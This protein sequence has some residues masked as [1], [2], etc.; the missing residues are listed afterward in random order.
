MT[1]PAWK[2][3]AVTLTVDVMAA[4]E[5]NARTAAL[6][7]V[8]ARASRYHVDRIV[9]GDEPRAAIPSPT[10]PNPAVQAPPNIVT[11]KGFEGG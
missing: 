2:K 9:S 8:P 1:D 5:E 3:W 7:V 6:W 11:K 4:T 10:S